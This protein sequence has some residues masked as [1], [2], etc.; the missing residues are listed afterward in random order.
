MI[1][2]TAGGTVWGSGIQQ[3]IE[4]WYKLALRTE[5]ERIEA[6]N[7][8]QFACNWRARPDQRGV[9]LR[10]AASQFLSPTGSKLASKAVNNG[11][12]T[13]NEWRERE[14]LPAADAGA[15][16]LTAGVNL[17]PIT[18]LGEGQDGDTSAL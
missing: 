9:R 13:R 11:L 2:D 15:D 10:R 8:I 7:C 5:L 4:G 17:A 6:S 16:T 12:M 14:W 1:N 18:S 3:I